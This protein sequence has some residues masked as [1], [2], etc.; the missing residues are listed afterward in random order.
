MCILS[1]LK[2]N[3]VAATVPNNDFVTDLNLT[4]GDTNQKVLNKEAL[5]SCN[6]IKPS[7]SA[8]AC[9]AD[10]TQLWLLLNHFS[11]VHISC[12]FVIPNKGT[13]AVRSDGNRLI[14]RFYYI[15]KCVF[16]FALMET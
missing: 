14:Y 3:Q 5:R 8:C 12:N 16:N 11:R 7:G 9:A 10:I 15:V 6:V 2:L 4:G 1:Y 13:Y